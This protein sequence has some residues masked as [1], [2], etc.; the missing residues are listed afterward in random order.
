LE[1]DIDSID[2]LADMLFGPDGMGVEN[3]RFSISPHCKMTPNER[4]EEL[5][6]VLEDLKS[7]NFEVVD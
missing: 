7:G 6:H 5:I 1:R 3:I 4:A 2:R